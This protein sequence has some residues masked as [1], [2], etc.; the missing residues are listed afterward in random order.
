MRK[1]RR[2]KRGEIQ[3]CLLILIPNLNRQTD[4]EVTKSVIK[5][6]KIVAASVAWDLNSLVLIYEVQWA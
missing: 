2:K 5:L 3:V 4:S 1:A 6:S